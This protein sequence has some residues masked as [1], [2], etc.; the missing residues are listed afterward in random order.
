M[1]SVH[2]PRRP[3]GSGG[4]GPRPGPPVGARRTHSPIRSRGGSSARTG[5][6][7][8]RKD[9]TQEEIEYMAKQSELFTRRIE[10]ERRR[11]AELDKKLKVSRVARDPP[12]LV[13]FL[14]PAPRSGR[15]AAG[16]GTR[17]GCMWCVVASFS[18]AHPA[19][20]LVPADFAREA[21][22]VP[23]CNRWPRRRRGRPAPQAQV[24][25]GAEQGGP[26]VETPE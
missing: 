2:V 13:A 8:A 14:A 5:T 26:H 24:Q 4:G 12:V 19:P 18:P 6:R 25:D 10:V 23:T 3:A 9:S 15:S 20:S 1:A 7:S 22:G 17:S 21:G 11:A 16:P